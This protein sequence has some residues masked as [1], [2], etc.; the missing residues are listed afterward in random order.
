MIKTLVSLY[1]EFT[2]EEFAMLLD[3]VKADVT[4]GEKHGV[5]YTDDVLKQVIETSGVVVRR[6]IDGQV[7]RA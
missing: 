4:F 2:K 7:K 5:I 3:I 6:V 1:K